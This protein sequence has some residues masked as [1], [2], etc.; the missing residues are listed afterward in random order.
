MNTMSAMDAIPPT[1]P[2]I[3][4]EL[5]EVEVEVADSTDVEIGWEDVDERELDPGF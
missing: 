5:L 1:T 3:M 4:P 2:P